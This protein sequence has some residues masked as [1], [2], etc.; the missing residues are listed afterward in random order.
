LCALILVGAYVGLRRT[1]APL[2]AAGLAP[3]AVP[4]LAEYAGSAACAECHAAAFA[5][6]QQSHHG[7]AERS[8]DPTNDLAAFVPPRVFPDGSGTSR[9][10]WTNGHA[11]VITR[12]ASNQPEVVR[13]ERVIGESPLQQFLVA[14]P[15]GRWQTLETTWDPHR[16][17]WFNVF[18]TD[19]RRAGEWGHWTGR[20]MNWNSMCAGCHNTRLQKN[21]APETDRYHTTMAE[22]SVGCEACHGPMKAHVAWRLKHPGEPT[23]DPTVKALTPG[24]MLDTCGSCH[25]RRSELTG[26]FV[27]GAAFTDHFTLATVDETDLYFPDGQVRDEDYEFASF[28]SSRMHAAGVRCS[29][30]HS[31]HSAKTLLPGN[32]LCLRCHSGGTPN[33][34]VINLLTHT[35]HRADS[36]GSQCVNCHM[37]QT[38]Y[39]QRHARHDHGFTI[40]DPL[41][42]QQLGVPNA[43]NRCHSDQAAAWALAAV[44]KWYGARMDRPSRH[45][46]QAIAAARR[47]DEAALA[48]LVALLRNPETPYWQAVAVRLL[49]PWLADPTVQPAILAL[50]H[51]TNAFLRAQVAQVLEPLAGV[52]GPVRSLLE[53][54]LTDPDR[55]VRVAA[56]WALRG[57]VALASPAGRDLTQ[58]L[59]LQADQPLGQLRLG[60]FHTARGELA[61]AREHFQRAVTWDP[62]SAPLRRELALALSQ[63][64][65]PG[66]AI[67]Q[68]EFAARLEPTEAEY[69]FLLALACGEAGQSQRVLPELEAALKLNPRHARAAYNLGLARQE[70]GDSA[71]AIEALLQAESADPR[72]PE[73]PYARATIHARIGQ[74]AAAR[75]AAQRALEL[76]PDSVA[77]RRLLDSL[78]P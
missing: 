40:P 41:L 62:N 76:Q 30:C 42:T 14:A 13:V 51:H 48:P 17:E 58:A 20:G 31:P 29:D 52:A 53:R 7:R 11:E 24:Q 72:D 59:A 23:A 44:E 50:A 43:C 22:R 77:A 27:P 32:A 16:Q 67:V 65:E 45:R 9:V 63:A 57:T 55:G 35:F 69:R 74:S 1:A 54:G 12:G 15:G 6:W 46:A 3:A 25:A 26:D 34:P 47:G 71:A 19:D 38:T 56:V 37:P 78:A 5:A 39:M 8:F 21:Y 70:R 10:R 18:G 4:A 64:G 2:P 75:A 66:G 68:L 28:L 33:A 73:I 49:A 60:Y 61:R 36:P